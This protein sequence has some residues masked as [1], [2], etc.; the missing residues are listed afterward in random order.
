MASKSGRPEGSIAKK[1]ALERDAFWLN[2]YRA[3]SFLFEHDLFGKPVSPFPDHA[4]AYAIC[5]P[6]RRSMFLAKP[7]GAGVNG[8]GGARVIRATQNNADIAS[9]KQSQKPSI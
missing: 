8:P 6:H 7:N 2:R 9:Q 5:I 4:V 1:W 3:L